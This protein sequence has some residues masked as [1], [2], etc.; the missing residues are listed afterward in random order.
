MKIH[1]WHSVLNSYEIGLDKQ[2]IHWDVQ[3]SVHSS[4]FLCPT[5]HLLYKDYTEKHNK[6]IKFKLGHNYKRQDEMQ[7]TFTSTTP[8]EY[9]V[10]L[11]YGMF[12]IT[13]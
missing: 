3:V 12:I 1:F 7:T 13:Y 5:S 6:F 9:K 4:T 11:L 2:L 10:G 8:T